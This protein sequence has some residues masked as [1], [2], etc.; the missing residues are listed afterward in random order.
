MS[1][2]IVKYDIVMSRYRSCIEYVFKEMK[3]VGKILSL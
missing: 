3:H 1:L 2:K